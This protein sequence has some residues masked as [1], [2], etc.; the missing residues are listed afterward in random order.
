MLFPRDLDRYVNQAV[1]KVEVSLVYSR[2]SWDGD[3]ADSVV[4]ERR[5]DL[6]TL[7]RSHYLRF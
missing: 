4:D 2:V 3:R 5:C 6:N 7:D 1:V